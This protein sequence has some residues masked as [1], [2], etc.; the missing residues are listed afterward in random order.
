MHSIPYEITS[1]IVR[2][3][4]VFLCLVVLVRTI[5]IFRATKLHSKNSEISYFA[6]LASIDVNREYHLGYDNTIGQSKRCDVQIHGKD[7]AKIH[8]Q[9]YKKKDHW[10]L[11]TYTRKTTLLNEIKVGGR[12]EIHSHDVLQL[13]NKHY[14]FLVNKGENT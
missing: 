10:M 9:I 14:R 11:C 4:L 6:K 7:I 8:I 3:I 12:I 5:F 2:Y 1:L 13:G